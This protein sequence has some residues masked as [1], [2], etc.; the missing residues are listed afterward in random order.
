MPPAAE[1]GDRKEGITV[2]TLAE[3]SA[4]YRETCVRLRLAIE[5]RQACQEQGSQTAQ[6]ELVLLRQML[7][8]MRE[9]RSL[10]EGYY[11]RPRTSRYTTV[12]LTAP[13]VDATK[14]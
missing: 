13:R 11:T 10:S 2:S 7:R 5:E 9:L 1:Y 8:E 3:L 12:G 14:R 6:R 4:Q